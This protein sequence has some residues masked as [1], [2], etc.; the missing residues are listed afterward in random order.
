MCCYVGLVLLLFG[1]IHTGTNQPA[2]QLHV[3]GFVWN[4]NSFDQWGVELGKV[5]ASKVRDAMAA[6]RSTTPD[7]EALS[8]FNSSTRKMMGMYLAGKTHATYPQAQTAF[9]ANVLRVAGQGN[10]AAPWTE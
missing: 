8:S 1:H 6:S 9:P 3:Q 10:G 5:L 4:I 7:I 2:T